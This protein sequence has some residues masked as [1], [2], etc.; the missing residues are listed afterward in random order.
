[1]F[2]ENDDF[3]KFAGYRNMVVEDKIEKCLAH[4]FQ[5]PLGAEAICGYLIEH[6]VEARVL[7]GGLARPF[8]TLKSSAPTGS[9]FH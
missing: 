2:F 9:A 8:P 3:M 1:M 7:T 5:E 6:G 4:E